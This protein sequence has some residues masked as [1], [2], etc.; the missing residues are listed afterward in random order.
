[1]A[2]ASGWP[3]FVGDQGDCVQEH[4]VLTALGE[5]FVL[6]RSWRLHYGSMAHQDVA[7]VPWTVLNRAGTSIYIKCCLLGTVIIQ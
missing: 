3:G 7:N 5:N 1:M 2:S 6:E 4:F